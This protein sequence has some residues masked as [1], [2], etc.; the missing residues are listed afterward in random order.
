MNKIAM[1]KNFDLGTELDISGAFIYNGLKSLHEIDTLHY[2]SDIF[3]IL[4]N[5]SVGIERLLKINIIL[6]EHT[7]NIDLNMFENSL[8]THNTMDLL[9]RIK[10]KV[11]I[12]LS[13]VHNNFIQML[14]EFY[15]SYRYSPVSESD[16]NKEKKSFHSFNEK[17][18]KFKIN[19]N[20]PFGITQIN[21]KL[22]KSI[23][24]V[25]GKIVT[26]LYTILKDESRRLN[27]FTD[28][29]RYNSKAGKIFMRGE[30]NFENEDILSKELLIFLINNKENANHLDFI[31]KTKHLDFDPS[32]DIEYINSMNSYEKKLDILDELESLYEDLEN[33]GDRLKLMNLIGSVGIEF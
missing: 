10:K 3:E 24:K 29:V 14:S 20:F 33:P 7:D 16:I 2:S 30:F 8:I 5:L 31:K 19:D 13:N 21:I 32:L 25:V 1:W 11:E 9:A 4:Y 23:G 27:L 18:F 26:S 17:E 22:K 6:L 12:P 28:E 15:K